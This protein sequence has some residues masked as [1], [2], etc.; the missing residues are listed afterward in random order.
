MDL[1]YAAHM[2]QSQLRIFIWNFEE[3]GLAEVDNGKRYRR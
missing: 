2:S 3:L 1:F